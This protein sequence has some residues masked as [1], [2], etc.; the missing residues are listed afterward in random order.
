MNS[1]QRKT[2]EKIW[3]HPPRQDINW[4]S[5]LSLIQGVGGKVVQ[6]SGSRVKFIVN[7]VRGYFHA[8]HKNGANMDKGAIADLKKFLENANVRPEE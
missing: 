1:K 7:G 6:G 3:E 5:I 8:P 2:L 4:K